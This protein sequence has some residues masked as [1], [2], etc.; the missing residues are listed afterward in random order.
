MTASAAVAAATLDDRG[1]RRVVFQPDEFPSLVDAAL[2]DDWGGELGTMHVVYAEDVTVP[3][4]RGR[5]GR[6]VLVVTVNRGW[7][8]AYYRSPD[9]WAW[10]TRNVQPAADTPEL[11]YDPEAGTNY[12]ADAA[13][14]IDQLRRAVEEYLL[15]GQRPTCVEWQAAEQYMIY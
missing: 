12:P 4:P 5:S 14:R 9:K 8:G 2:V 13:I 15:T 3:P 7:G 1:V 10:I 11:L 6:S